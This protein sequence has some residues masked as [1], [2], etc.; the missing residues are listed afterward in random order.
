MN[1]PKTNRPYVGGS[2]YRM[3]FGKYKDHMICTVPLWYLEWLEKEILTSGGNTS[4]QLM[5]EIDH[6]RKNRG[7]K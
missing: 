7:K 4:G 3:P 5:K 6:E 1:T 2:A